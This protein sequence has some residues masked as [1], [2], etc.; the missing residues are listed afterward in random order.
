VAL[1]PSKKGCAGMSSTDRLKSEIENHLGFFP[2]HFQPLLATPAMLEH[3]W[4]LW[5]SVYTVER[6]PLIFKEKAFAY[7]ARF[8]KSPYFLICQSSSLKEMGMTGQEI[9]MWLNKPPMSDLNFQEL[10]KTLKENRRMVDAWP[11]EESLLEKALF[12]SLTLLYHKRFEV[13]FLSAEIHRILGPVLY[14]DFLNLLIFIKTSH[15]LTE[16]FPSL[17]PEADK[18][19]SMFRAALLAEEPRLQDFFNSY[20]EK[21]LRELYDID[22]KMIGEFPPSGIHPE[23]AHVMNAKLKT[24]LAEAKNE[25]MKLN[26]EKLRIP[27]QEAETPFKNTF[28][29]APDIIYRLDQKGHFV[30][31]NNTVEVL[32][33]KPDE[34]MG[35]HFSTILHEE[36]VKTVSR[37]EV[38]P[39]Y[40]GENTGERNAPKLF[41]ERR[42]G[43][44]MTKDLEVR[45]LAKKS[46][47]G[48]AAASY[49]YG[50]VNCCGLYDEELSRKK[51]FLGTVGIIR[52][53]TDRKKIERTRDGFLSTVSHEL[54][55]PAAVIKEAVYSLQEGLAG[56]LTEDQMGFVKLA[57]RN[58]NRLSKIINNILDLSRLESRKVDL[59]RRSIS[60]EKIIRDTLEN[61]ASVSKNKTLSVE[62]E[63]IH[64]PL[65]IQAD[66]DLMTVVF[67]NLIDN[68]IRFSQ[69]KVIVRG[70]YI[71]DDGSV[72]KEKTNRVLVSVMDDGPGIDS[73]YMKNL[74]NKYT[75]IN[76]PRNVS[77]YKGTGLGLVICKE[78]IHLHS[79]KIWVES[80]PN[81]GAYFH[82]ILPVF[83]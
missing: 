40:T 33:F 42:T 8:V 18:R 26:A 76:R 9:L 61:F 36:D 74:F 27:G 53:T 29:N 77:N 54:R 39:L 80:Y 71:D 13:H 65:N 16:A 75:Q 63:S 82:F 83:Q 46:S 81:Q 2:P 4:K 45:L 59:F 21:S 17:A 78:I 72:S 52:N 25:L 11:T 66:E 57:H 14:N 7:A 19:V 32:G 44:R 15:E 56:P 58:A 28:K 68:A 69:S 73:N 47:D 51:E 5:I 79:G 10:L 50:E 49:Y 35:R 1:P 31:V 37:S 23:F 67:N 22:L 38:L 12:E 34:L 48:P 20:Y 62:I 6:I 30:Y 70:T 41:D 43:N 64:K 60:L 3:V 24:E 55:T